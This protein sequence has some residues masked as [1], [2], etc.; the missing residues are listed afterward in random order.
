MRVLRAAMDEDGPE[1]SIRNAW[2]TDDWA[3][4]LALAEEEWIKYQALVDAQEAKAKE[5]KY[6]KVPY[7]SVG[8]KF[9]NLIRLVVR[10]E[11]NS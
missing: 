2:V 10:E 5:P 6:I 7:E 11:I 4:A 8:D 1:L 9:S 3:T